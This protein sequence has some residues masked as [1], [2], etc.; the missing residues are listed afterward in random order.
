M[1]VIGDALDDARAARAVGVECILYD[2]GS[3]HRAELDSAGVA[4]ARSLVEA[5]RLAGAV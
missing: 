4:V 5:V 2:G 3:H 1:V